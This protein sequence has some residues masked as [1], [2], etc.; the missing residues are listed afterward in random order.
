MIS[1][2]LVIGV[3]VLV[4]NNDGTVDSLQICVFSL[5][6]ITLPHL[7]YNLDEL[8]EPLNPVHQSTAR[9]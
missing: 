1:D 5:A 8:L 7:E 9:E 6:H 2:I 4:A 3:L